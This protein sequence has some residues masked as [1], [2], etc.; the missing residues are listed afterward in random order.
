[1]F[2]SE[3]VTERG[4]RKAEGFVAAIGDSWHSLLGPSNAEKK[5]APKISANRR[6]KEILFQM[7]MIDKALG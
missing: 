5:K 7:K 4:E 3:N 6:T 2:Y 1:M